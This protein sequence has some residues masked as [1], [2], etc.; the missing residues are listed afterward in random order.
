MTPKEL[1]KALE[2]FGTDQQPM[3]IGLLRSILREMDRQEELK[4][5]RLSAGLQ[6]QKQY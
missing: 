3:T 2:G 5:K 6:N 1:I 4:Q